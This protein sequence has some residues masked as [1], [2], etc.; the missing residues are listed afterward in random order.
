MFREFLTGLRRRRE[1]RRGVRDL[2]ALDDRALDD[3]GYSRGWLEE[4]AIDPEVAG[5]RELRERARVE[6]RDPSATAPP[7][8]RPAL[9]L[10]QP[11][12]CGC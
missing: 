2:L 4:A 3:I 7:A 1:L 11:A 12:T 8:R 6:L 10:V 9:R 5:F